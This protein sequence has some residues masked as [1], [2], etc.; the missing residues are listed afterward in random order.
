[1]KNIFAQEKNFEVKCVFFSVHIDFEANL[2]VFKNLWFI[3]TF[4]TS[5]VVWQIFVNIFV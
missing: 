3:S 5:H 1:M 2:F 4:D